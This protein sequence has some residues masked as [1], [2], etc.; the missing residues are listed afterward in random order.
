MCYTPYLVNNP[1]TKD[2][3]PVPCGKCPQCTARRTSGWS[4]RLVQQEKVSNKSSFITLTYDTKFVPISRNGFMSLNKRDLQ[5]FLKGY[6]RSLLSVSD[7][8]ERSSIMQ[9][10]NTVE[11]LRDHT[12]TL[13]CLMLNMTTSWPHG[14]TRKQSN[15]S[16]VFISVTYQEHQS[17]ILSSISINQAL[18][19]F[20]EMMIESRNSD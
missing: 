12:I 10:V 5:L 2:K 17:G 1:E 19:R 15:L 9:L 14:V 6:E 20:T 4:F 18:D 13:Y 11:K 7:E 3:I 16:G 8:M